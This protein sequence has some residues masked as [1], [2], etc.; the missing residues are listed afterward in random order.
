[1]K[2]GGIEYTIEYSDT[3]DGQAGEFQM[4]E[5]LHSH[6]PAD[7]VCNLVA[8][9]YAKPELKQ[10]VL[11]ALSPFQ[12]LSKLWASSVLAQ[13]IG[14]DYE[15][16]PFV[17]FGSWFGQLNSLMSRR[18]SGYM[19]RPV[20]MIDQDP[21]ACE[22]AKL[23]LEADQWQTAKGLPEHI[24]IVN[25][26]CTHFDL[27][28]FAD[29]WGAAPIVVWTGVEHFTE[30][31]VVE[32]IECNEDCN[33]VYLLQGTNM[34]A[35]DHINLIQGFRQLEQY[36]DGDPIYSACLRTAIG[37]RFQTVFAT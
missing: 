25:G 6:L 20:T 27:C 5:Y 12:V 13:I 36:F 14:D 35:D 32:Y 29:T 9:T 30:K 17:Y 22:I 19:S 16:S 7:L 11:D 28:A 21:V 4:S 23:V 10:P 26:D 1:M 8:Q 33:A 18:V 34:P 3:I 24:Q 2:L 31:S 37:D 15:R